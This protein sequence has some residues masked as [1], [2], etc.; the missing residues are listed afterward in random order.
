MTPAIPS[1]HETLVHVLREHAERRRDSLAMTFLADG[2]S[3]SQEF[4][5]H[6]LDRRIRAVAARLQDMNTEGERALLLFESDLDFVIAFL[7]CLY[8]RV[9]AVPAYPPRSNPHHLQRLQALVADAQAKVVLATRAITS[10][11]KEQI[12]QLPV[13]ASARWI[14]LSEVGEGAA[15]A[16]KMPDLR[17][18]TLAFLQY[19]SGSLGTPKGVMVSHGNLLHNS[20][21]IA[22]AFQHSDKTVYVGWLPLFHDMGLIGNVLQS[23][24]LGGRCISMPPA[25]FIQKPVRWLR[26]ISTYGATTSGAP[27]SAYDLCARK[28]TDDQLEGINLGTWH[29][30]YNGAEPVRADVIDAFARRF[31]PYGFR[32]PA[33]YPCYGMAES[34]LI[35]S[36][37]D[38]LTDLSIRSVD[39]AALE[40]GLVADAATGQ[41]A[42]RIVSCGH[43]RLG[44]EVR[45]VD[46]ATCIPCPPGK[47]GEI[48]LAGASVALG[49]W[50]RA[51]LTREVFQARV[52]DSDKPFLRTGDLGFVEGSQLYVTGRLKDLIIIHGRNHY[53][54]DI[55]ATAGQSSKVLRPGQGAAFS[56]DGPESEVLVV[57]HEVERE[58]LNVLDVP[59]VAGQIRQAVSEEHEL[60]VHAVVLLKPGS[61]PKTSS[62][63]VQRSVCRAHF[64]AGTLD[65]V[66]QWSV[67]LT[68]PA[69]EA[70]PEAP[71][72]AAHTAESI[73]SW[74][75]E[76]VAARLRI[77]AAQIDT[78]EPLAHYGLESTLA[79]SL[80]GEL[81]KRLGVQLEPLIFWEYPS[82]EQL[83][84]HLASL[85]P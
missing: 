32:R 12:T 67:P 11:V 44:Q 45:I 70:S 6:E 4:T 25:A 42:R 27:S 75:V 37:G 84:E 64:L 40:K 66:G 85:S 56:I 18:E 39:G 79:V 81:G 21:Q 46:P 58:A 52:P 41:P 63:K 28:I 36:G 49:Y 22:D 20:A 77:A 2:E 50:N 23:L 59:A 29:V 16:W 17:G 76:R 1:H 33:M 5:F 9:V 71:P 24:Y 38:A 14:D 83:S 78:Q 82:I 80:T 65:A 8:A 62:G 35:I 7:G 69:P 30:A 48:W 53:P 61:L 74:L 3:V 26:A 54:Q 13:L 10:R 15:D 55:E 57:V 68:G 47:V 72:P 19:T 34:T 73:Q 51:E 60:L 43:T 31:A